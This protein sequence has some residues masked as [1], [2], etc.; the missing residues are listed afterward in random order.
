MAIITQREMVVQLM[1]LRLSSEI[2]AH[3]TNNAMCNL[4]RMKNRVCHCMRC[5][6]FPSNENAIIPKWKPDY[7]SIRK[8]NASTMWVKKWKNA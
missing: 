7:N 8:P 3:L 2:N 5:K 6:S 1:I 4:C